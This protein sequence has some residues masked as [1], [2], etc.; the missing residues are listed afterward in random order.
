MEAFDATL[1]NRDRGSCEG[2]GGSEG[3]V[4][5]ANGIGFVSFAAS[6]SSTGIALFV[7]LDFMLLSR[8]FEAFRPRILFVD[9]SCACRGEEKFVTSCECKDTLLLSVRCVFLCFNASRPSV[10]WAWPGIGLGC[11]CSVVYVVVSEDLDRVTFDRLRLIL[12]RP[13]GLRR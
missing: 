6:V 7:R 13:D 12:T 4:S 2:G 5:S 8:N 1:K 3:S 10:A 11:S 9:S